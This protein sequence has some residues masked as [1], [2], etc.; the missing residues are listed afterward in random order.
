PRSIGVGQYQHD[1]NPN[2][3]GKSLEEVVESCVNKVGVNLNT[4]S[5]KL[6]GYV[7]GVGPTLAKN[8]VEFRNKNG[9]FA[10]RDDLMKVSGLGPKAYQQAAGFIR[11]PD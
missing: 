2:K 5:Y 1:V 10:S 4:A 3:L 6:L 8:I 7:S 9:R 11:V